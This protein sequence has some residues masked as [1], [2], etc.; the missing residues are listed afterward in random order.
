[1]GNFFRGLIRA[2]AFIQKE[3]LE[4]LRQPQLVGALV[5]GPFLILFVFGIGYR[6][7]PATLRTLFVTPPNSALSAEDIER[8]GKSLGDIFIYSGV[9]DNQAEA[10]NRLHQG[11]VDLVVVVPQN[12]TDTLKDN[13][14]SVFTFYHN[15]IDPA[16]VSY[17]N[18]LG[19]LYVGQVNQQ[20]LR[21]LVLQAQKETVNLHTSLQDAHQNAS[22]MRQAIQSGNDTL[23]QQKQQ[24]L[25]GNVDAL[26]LGVGVSLGLLDSLQHTTG[27]GGTTTDPLQSALADLR[28]N[29]N[30]LATSPAGSAERLAALDK[31]DKD[32]T[33]LDG[34]LTEFQGIDAGIVVSPFRNEIKSVAN[35]QPSL[36]D[37]F[38][39]AVLA[40]L[41]QHLAV[42]FA[43]LSIVHERNAGTLEL[44]HVSPLS[45]LETLLGK[46]I[47]Y[48]LFGSVI[49]AILSAVLIFILH[50][51]MLG[52]WWYFALVI[53]AVLFT[54]LGIGFVIS[55]ISQTDSQ[56]V[57]YSMIILL[58][59]VVFS[60]FIISLEMFWV[61]VRI[62]SW[63][64]PTTYGT[65]LLRDI[66]LRGADPNWWLLAGLVALGAVL[67]LLSWQLMR[68][69]ISSSK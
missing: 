26:S 31:V 40:L 16:Q 42:T 10:L 1:M 3:I 29:S 48:M 57:Q 28:Q 60:G 54:S 24:A 59:S 19:W 5:L 58:A 30:S 68:R 21:D 15:E 33:D 6:A 62:I 69:L 45:A 14:Q 32:I 47:S 34:K 22:D 11:Q 52:N 12:V 23:A 38:A 56:A 8:Y 13:Q 7:Q 17:V 37:F 53:V 67:M 2:S 9:I 66:A 49:G 51:P 55:L 65:L 44:F 43:A 41:L 27:S 36:S 63:L 35:I 50:V 4:I 64:L 18:Y 20:V 61:P 39:P 46:F 25:A